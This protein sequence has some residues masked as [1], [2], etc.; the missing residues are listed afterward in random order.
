MKQIMLSWKSDAFLNLT[1]KLKRI[2]LEI[3]DKRNWLYGLPAFFQQLNSRTEG[4]YWNCVKRS[5]V[6]IDETTS[7]Q[8]DSKKIYVQYQKN[9]VIQGRV[10]LRD[11]FYERVEKLLKLFLKFEEYV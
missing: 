9:F 7:K 3:F 6:Q 8:F 10:T 5:S 4:Q 2:P 11:E 1:L